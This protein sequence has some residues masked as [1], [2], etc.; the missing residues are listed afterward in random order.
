M[1]M[2]W[3][4]CFSFAQEEK[5]ELGLS[6]GGEFIPRAAT[7]PNQKLSFGRSVAYSVGYA[8]RLSSGNIADAPGV[9]VRCRA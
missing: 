1:S 2:L 3:M 9:S 5:N 7:T 8:R 4:C 6:L